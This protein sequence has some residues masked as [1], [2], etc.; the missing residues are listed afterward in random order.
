MYPFSCI[1]NYGIIYCTVIV[2]VR[3]PVAVHGIDGNVYCLL[4]CRCVP[5]QLYTVLMVICTLLY[6]CCVGACIP[7]AIHGIDGIMYCTVIV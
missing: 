5:L 2:Q 3:T 1:G 7:V 4:L 6:C